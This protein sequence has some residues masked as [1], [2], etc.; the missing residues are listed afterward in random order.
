MKKAAHT[1]E[2]PSPLRDIAAEVATIKALLA[3]S[4]AAIP[5]KARE[6]LDRIEQIATGN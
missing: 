1:E 6:A 5:K 3:Q 2:A 4:P